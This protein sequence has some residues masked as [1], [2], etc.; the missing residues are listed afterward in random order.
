MYLGIVP[1]HGGTHHDPSACLVADGHIIAFVEQER[2]SRKKHATGQ[3]PVEAIE[4][5]LEIGDIYLSNVD[6]IGLSRNYD[7]RKKSFWRLARRGFRSSSSSTLERLFDSTVVPVKQAYA[8]TNGDLRSIT[9]SR[10]G[11][12][13][14]VDAEDIP[15]INF[16]NHHMTH[17]ASAF[18][19]SGFDEALV[20]SLDNYGGHLSGGIY[21]G[22]GDNIET[23]T[24]FKRFNSLGRFYGDFTEYLGF[25]R[26]N[27]EGKVMGLAPY[28]S[29]NE[30]VARVVSSYYSVADGQYDVEELTF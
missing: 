27:G 7:N 2:M 16:L 11:D 25:R 19:P 29:H 23:K 13:F 6:S 30:E 10:L 1:A 18:Y 9:T 21:F 14:D 12:H 15:P 28:G 24:T 3:F 4:E 22:R 20:V 26:S 5:C 8:H 17:A